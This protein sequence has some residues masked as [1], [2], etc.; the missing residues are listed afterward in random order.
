V[1][2][3][4]NGRAEEELGMVMWIIG[5]QFVKKNFAKNLEIRKNIR[6]FAY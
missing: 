4:C 5:G 2:A 1:L 6:I 3:T